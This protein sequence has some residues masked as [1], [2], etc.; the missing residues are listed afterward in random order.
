MRF[1]LMPCVVPVVLLGTLLASWPGSALATIV[2]STFD[3]D[4]EGWTVT[5]DAQGGSVVPDYF[6]SG[7]NPGGYILADDNTTGGIWYW[8]AP[9]KFRGD[10]SD[11][12]GRTLSFELTQTPTHSQ[13]DRVD[14][15]LVGGGY[16][17]V[18]DT[19]Y[20]PGTSWTSYSVPLTE[21]GGWSVGAL[22][23]PGPSQSQMQ[24]VLANIG[25]L[26]IRG[27]FVNGSDVG[28]L[29]N[30]IM[31]PESATLILMV[32]GLPLLLWRRGKPR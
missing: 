15:S 23:A 5:G 24:Q 9:A 8:K 11:A 29:D 13:I 22:G 7:G 21:L 18:Y 4:D 30:V 31:I 16:T 19:A 1:R 3:A 28:R 2:E 25:D 27:E 17:L 14:I 6:S 12:Y 10:H 26:Q 32:G 20:N